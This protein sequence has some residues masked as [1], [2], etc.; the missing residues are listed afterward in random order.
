MI[1]IKI[2]IYPHALVWWHKYNDSFNIIH[3]GIKQT[4]CA[5]CQSA[6]RSSSTER[7]CDGRACGGESAE[8]R[9]TTACFFPRRNRILWST[10]PQNCLRLQHAHKGCVVTCSQSRHAPVAPHANKPQALSEENLCV[11]HL[12]S[13]LLLFKRITFIH[14]F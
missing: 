10:P 13:L 5:R 11:Y 1:T 7:E 12:D 9:W 4:N 14:S 6:S 8:K 3:T 2:I